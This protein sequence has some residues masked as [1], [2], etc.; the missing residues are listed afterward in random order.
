MA[1]LSSPAPTP[2]PCQGTADGQPS[3]QHDGHGV[4]SE[5]FGQ[6][7]GRVVK[8]DLADDK[9]VEADDFCV[10]QAEISLC[11]VGLLIA[12]GVPGQEAVEFG[13]TAGE[14]VDGVVTAE[15]FDPKSMRHTSRPKV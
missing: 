13:L 12:V 15:L 14:A 3:Q 5:A 10:V 11:G 4:A 8:G 1:S 7:S 6:S 2:L 9:A